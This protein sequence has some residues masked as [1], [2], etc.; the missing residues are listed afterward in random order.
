MSNVKAFVFHT[1]IGGAAYDNGGGN[2]GTGFGDS[3]RQIRTDI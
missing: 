3:G 2:L 1:H